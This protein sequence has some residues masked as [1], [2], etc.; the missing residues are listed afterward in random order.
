MDKVGIK[1]SMDWS[2]KGSIKMEG[3][4]DMVIYY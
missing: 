4:M 3:K 2:I 1:N